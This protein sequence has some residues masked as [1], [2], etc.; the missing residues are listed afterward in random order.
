MGWGGRWPIISSAAPLPELFAMESTSAGAPSGKTGPVWG[1]STDAV[2]RWGSS[3]HSLASTAGTNK[4]ML[5]RIMMGKAC[6]HSEN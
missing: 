6:T 4:D 1:G 5:F 3:R 2:S